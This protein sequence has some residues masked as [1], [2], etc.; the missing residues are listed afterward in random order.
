MKG[1]TFL[2]S[3]GSAAAT[4]FRF[5]KA[6]DVAGSMEQVQPRCELRSGGERLLFVLVEDRDGFKAI[7]AGPAMPEISGASGRRR[8][9]PF[10]Q[11]DRLA[12]L[13]VGILLGQKR[14]GTS[15]GTL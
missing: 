3:T 1:A 8:L 4:H 11:R 14:V 7:V 15:H 6:A 5:C 13:G 12:A 10:G 9:D 2:H